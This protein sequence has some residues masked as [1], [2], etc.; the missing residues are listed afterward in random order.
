MNKLIILILGLISVSCSS[1]E[2]ERTFKGVYSYG[3]E[4]HS[5]TPCNEKNDYWVSFNWAGI[6][7]HEFYKEFSQE[8]YQ[9]MYLEFRGLLLNERVDG[10]AEQYDGLVRVSE[11]FNYTFEVPS[12]CR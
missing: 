1:I 7:M 9:L 3:H 4:V 12:E 2:H 11:V 8:P 6:E 10:F 5:F